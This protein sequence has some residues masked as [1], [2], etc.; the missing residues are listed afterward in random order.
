[1][2]LE[3]GQGQSLYTGGTNMF[4]G[5]T[6]VPPLCI[7]KNALRNRK[8]SSNGSRPTCT[9]YNGKQVTYHKHKGTRIR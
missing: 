2:F 6:F 3:M 9:T 5:G 4:T 7:L 1:M 8:R